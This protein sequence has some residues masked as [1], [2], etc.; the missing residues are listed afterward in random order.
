MYSRSM[1]SRSSSVMLQAGLKLADRYTVL[2]PISSGAMGAVYR[3]RD[4]QVDRDVA[5][6]RLT[7]RR[8]A[9]RF[10]IEARL[11]AALHHPRVVEVI[12]YFHDE[13]GK[14]LVM[15]LI[16]G[17]ELGDLLNRQGNPGLPLDEAIEYAR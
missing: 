2:E 17:T 7:D 13:S 11:L 14:Y 5:L 8:H 9:A 10:D 3:G 4:S 12:D 15:Q 6:K 16:E 1:S